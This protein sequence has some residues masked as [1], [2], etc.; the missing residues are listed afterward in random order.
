MPGRPGRRP[1]RP[2]SLGFPRCGR[3][4]DSRTATPHAARAVQHGGP[5][6]RRGRSRRCRGRRGC[7]PRAGRRGTYQPCSRVP[8]PAWNQA[9]SKASPCGFQSPSGYFEGKKISL[10]SKII[11]STTTISSP[12]PTARTIR[13]SIGSPPRRGPGRWSR[14]ASPWGR[15]VSAS[16]GCASAAG[17]WQSS[18][19]SSWRCGAGRSIKQVASMRH[20]RTLGCRRPAGEYS[21]RGRAAVSRVW[22]HSIR[23]G[24]PRQRDLVP[25]QH[26]QPRLAPFVPLLVTRFTAKADRIWTKVESA[27]RRMPKI[28]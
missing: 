3:N 27:S 14:P 12:S 16:G 15:G 25:Q 13:H 22:A 9:S 21:R 2:C 26:S 10:F 24:G 4:R 8:S 28:W 6:A 18:G 17:R 23:A 7:T 11:S 1:A 20:L 19:G 5:S